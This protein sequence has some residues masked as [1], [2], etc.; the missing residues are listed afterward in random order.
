MSAYAASNASTPHLLFGASNLTYGF[1]ELLLRNLGAKSGD[2][3]GNEL[4]FDFIQT[5]VQL[6]PAGCVPY[7]LDRPF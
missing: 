7:R 6:A 5:T 2:A 1:H 3:G 4:L